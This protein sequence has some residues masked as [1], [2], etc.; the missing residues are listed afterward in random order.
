MIE[1]RAQRI[2]FKTLIV[3]DELGQSTAG[4]RALRALIGELASWEIEVVEANSAEDGMSVIVSDAALHSILLDWDLGDDNPKTHSKALALVNLVRS[5][6][7]K[8][9]IFLMAEREEASEIPVTVMQMADEFIWKLGDT[10]EFIGGRIRAAMERYRDQL[11]PPMTAALAKFRFVHEYSWHTPGH[12]GGTAFLKSPVGR[13]FYDYFGENLLRS[14]L[15]ISVGEL[16]SLLDHTGP[17]GESEK[18]AARVFGS[19]R[20][21]CVTNGSSTSNRILF[22]AAISD[23]QIAL[24]DRNCHK[25]IEHGLTLTGAIPQYLVP[26]RNRYGIIGPIP[27]DRLTADALHASI[28][29]NPLVSTSTEEK[30]VFCVVTNSTYDGLCYNVKLLVEL[31]D[32]TVDRIHFDEAWYAY[33]RFNPIYRERFGM[34]GNPADHKGPTVFTTHSTHKLLAALSQASFLHVR[35]G[36]NPIDHPRFNESFMMHSSTS[37]LYPIIAS[38]DV[39]AAMMDGPGGIALTTESIQEAV[40]FRQTIGRIRKD[41]AA[42][43][44]WFFGTWNADEV[45]DPKNG[46]RIPFESAPAQLLTTEP[47]CWVLRPGDTWHGFEGMEDGYC[48]LD[49][50]KV[51]VLTPGVALDGSLQ[52]PGIPA[53]LVTAYLGGRGIQVE[54]TTDFTILFL[55]SIGITKGKWGTLVNAF[56]DFKRDYDLNAP[57]SQALPGLVRN[58]P[59]RYSHLGLR[60]LANAMFAQLQQSRQTHW[61]AQAFSTL[62]KPFMTPRDAYRRLVLNQVEKIPLDKLEDCVV[63]TGVVPYPPGIPML[64]PGENTGATNGPYLSYLQALQSWDERFP[65]FGH[66]THGVENIDGTYYIYCVKKLG[67]PTGVLDTTTE[68]VETQGYAYGRRG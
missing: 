51:S 5:R 35:D 62:P 61:L 47:D 67:R 64:M 58:H 21:Y 65:G 68:V 19:H 42:N 26:T 29:S 28:A 2:H 63:A 9:P 57:L 1:R 8:V 23:G 53:S 20:S 44:E 32:P 39:T 13:V 37:P 45:V 17:I 18:Y 15:S 54:K 24:C 25:S 59:D 48:M 55:F 16:G 22:M 41:F 40:A 3:D 33:A 34:H 4:A 12:T 31:L 66:D 30:P 10:A 60:D 6:D 50:I 46:T 36:R 27:P 14:D 56:L 38:N 11:L 52:G 49:P 7:D 43:G